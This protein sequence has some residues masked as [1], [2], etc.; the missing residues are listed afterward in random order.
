MLLYSVSPSVVVNG[1]TVLPVKSKLSAKVD[2]IMGAL[3]FQIGLPSSTMSYCLIEESLLAMAGRAL[4]FCS[5]TLRST[6]SS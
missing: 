6:V 5:W 2:M 1:K 3:T 4:A